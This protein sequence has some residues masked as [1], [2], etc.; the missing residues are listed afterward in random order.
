MARPMLHTALTANRD[1]SA[2]D[3]DIV[4]TSS[5][6]LRTRLKKSP[7]YISYIKSLFI[8]ADQ[9]A[10]CRFMSSEKVVKTGFDP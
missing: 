9:Y 2:V 6:E 7:S 4:F 10:R 1:M 3:L 5:P 8:F